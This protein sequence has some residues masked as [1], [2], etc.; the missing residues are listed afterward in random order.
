MYMY[1]Y[2]FTYPSALA[3]CDTWSVF[4]LSLAGLNAEF[5]FF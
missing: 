4:K 5:S 3:G 1:V 2:V